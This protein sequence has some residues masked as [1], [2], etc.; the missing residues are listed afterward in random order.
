MLHPPSKLLSPMFN[1]ELM[2]KMYLMGKFS[3]LFT[4]KTGVQTLLLFCA[5]LFSAVA[6]GE[7]GEENKWIGEP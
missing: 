2:G 5:S 6:E 1:R 3:Q 7:L 4:F